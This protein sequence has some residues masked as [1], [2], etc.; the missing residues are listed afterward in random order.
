MEPRSSSEVKHTGFS[1]GLN[2]GNERER[3]GNCDYWLYI[4]KPIWKMVPFTVS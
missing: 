3:S 2:V 4:Y 1:Y